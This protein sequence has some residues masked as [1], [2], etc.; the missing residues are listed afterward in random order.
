[1]TLV[2]AID[3]PDGAGKSIAAV[4][5]EGGAAARY[6]GY[7]SG[8]IKVGNLLNLFS[9]TFGESI[10]NRKRF[11]KNGLLVKN[12][13]I[14][15]HS[16][17]SYSTELVDCVVTMDR[18]KLDKLVGLKTDI[19]EI[20]E[21]SHL[22]EPL[23]K[24]EQVI[25]PLEQKEDILT[26]IKIFSACVKLLAALHPVYYCNNLL[27]Y[28]S[29]RRKMD[30]TLSDDRQ[31]VTGL[32]LMLC[33][34]PGTGK[35]MMVNAAVNSLGKKVLLVDMQK[36]SST[37]GNAVAELFQEAE[38]SDAVLFFDECEAVFSQRGTML[39]TLLTSIERFHGLVFLATNKPLDI[40][41]AMHRR[42]S[43]VYMFRPPNC[44]QRLLL[45]DSFRSAGLQFHA[46][47][48][49]NTISMKYEL[50]GGFIK[51]AVMNALMMACA[52][53]VEHPVINQEDL[54]QGCST[55]MRG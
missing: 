27:R 7:G 10:E 54:V 38:L 55:Q 5:F 31:L 12:G 16:P 25:L 15:I 1:M 34:P 44:Q 9:P 28:R 45:W 53:D 52:R 21:G 8:E 39:N 24:T 51:N 4:K 6:S 33:G 30:Q 35:T 14:I 50:T 2:V 40:D 23:T 32:V 37:E 48:D 36:L 3:A 11:G 47:I 18:R 22:Y 29:H 49:W 17:R 13:F 20:L 42:I 46:D 26:S 41:E 19:D 43:R